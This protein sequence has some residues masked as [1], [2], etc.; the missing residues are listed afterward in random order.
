MLKKLLPL[1]LIAGLLS[2]N[3]CDTE[4]T[5][6]NGKVYVSGIPNGVKTV[7]LTLE[8]EDGMLTVKRAVRNGRI[9]PVP[10]GPLFAG[11][12]YGRG[13]IKLDTF[14]ESGEEK[15]YQNKNAVEVPGDGTEKDIPLS[16]FEEI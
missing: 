5:V 15:N 16:D 4:V 9:A 6:K 7:V 2:I 10:L 14:S 11:K 8:T 1:I 13:K 12:T 3:A